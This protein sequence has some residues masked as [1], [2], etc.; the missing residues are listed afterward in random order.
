MKKMSRINI[1]LR[2]G[3]V[4][5]GVLAT[6]GAHAQVYK[7]V[8]AGGA[9]VY[10]QSPCPSGAKSSV[11]SQEPRPAAA[12]A[13]G[14]KSAKP[15]AESAADKEM[16]YRKRQLDR[17]AADKKATEQLAE[18]KRKQDDCRRARE[19][20]AQYDIGGRLSRIDSKGERYYMGDDEIALERAK[21]Q[22]VASQACK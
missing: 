21:A 14:S 19:A 10:S 6:T 1:L 13:P 17:E 20:I 15:G 22:A 5:I 2:A 11:I 18:E 3:L 8:G 7:C 12:E 9:T 16:D 4:A